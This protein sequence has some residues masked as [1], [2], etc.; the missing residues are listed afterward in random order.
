[1]RP[2]PGTYDQTQQNSSID[3]VDAR[4]EQSSLPLQWRLKQSLLR[5][6]SI[7]SMVKSY[8]FDSSK[9]RHFHMARES[10]HKYPKP[11]KQQKMRT[12]LKNKS[13]H[14]LNQSMRSPVNQNPDK[15]KPL[16]RLSQSPEDAR[17][18]Q[19]VIMVSTGT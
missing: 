5:K 7:D 15:S 18:E 10:T 6:K 19:S 13:R 4:S 14:L 16:W 12:S 2:G 8:D 1:M 9:A 17:H 3:L 11:T